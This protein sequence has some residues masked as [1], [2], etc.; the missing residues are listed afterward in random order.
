[1]FAIPYSGTIQTYDP[2]GDKSKII[3]DS[4]NKYKRQLQTGFPKPPEHWFPETDEEKEIQKKNKK[5]Q[6]KFDRGHKRWKQL[7]ESIDVSRLLIN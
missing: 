2:F 4:N 7:P 1:M 5:K 6:K 3:L